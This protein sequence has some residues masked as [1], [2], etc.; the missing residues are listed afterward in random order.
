MIT[1]RLATLATESRSTLLDP[2]ESLRDVFGGN[3]SIAGPRVGTHTAM[4]VPAFY[5]GVKILAE[6]IGSMPCE[7]R[8]WT[9]VNSE[10]SEPARTS[11]LW[12]LLHDTPNREMHA[13]DF[14]E[15]VTAHIAIAGNAYLWRERDDFGRVIGLWPLLP[16]LVDVQRD[17][18]TRRKVFLVSEDPD[19]AVVAPMWTEDILHLRGFGPHALKGLSPIGAMR[20]LLGRGI[21]EQEYQSSTLRNG[22]RPSGVLQTDGKIDPVKGRRLARRFKRAVSGTRRAGETIILEHG[23]KWQQVSLSAADLQF[24]EQRE[25]TVKDIARILR[26]PADMLLVSNGGDMHYTS[27]ESVGLRFLAWTMTPWVRRLTGPVGMDP[28]LPWTVGSPA[29]RMF[30]HFQSDL[31]LRADRKTR[32]EAWGVALDKG[33][34]SPDEVRVAEGRRPLG[35]GYDKPRRLEPPTQQENRAR[36]TGDV[37]GDHADVDDVEHLIDSVLA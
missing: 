26:I 21:A 36:P 27:D 12:T 35:T 11:R 32:F 33:W 13:G 18:R 2:S 16:G 1:E 29:G 20:E 17:P 19:S 9:E 4:T 30:P 37:A 8:R 10:V 31:L 22:A 25:F 28:Q 23:L 6:T 15:V 5:A 24:I 14:W 34:M 3:A 7:V